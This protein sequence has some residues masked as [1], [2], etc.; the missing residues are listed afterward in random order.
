M[1]EREPKKTQRWECP[2]CNEVTVHEIPNSDT[3]SDL[4]ASDSEVPFLGISGWTRN[5][6]CVKCG[7]RLETFEATK[8][9][10]VK[11]IEGLDRLRDSKS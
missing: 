9:E 4:L 1:A 5:R 8:D 2:K 7:H 11:L 10:I 6:I 3:R